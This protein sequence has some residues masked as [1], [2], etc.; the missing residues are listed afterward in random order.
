MLRL[1]HKKL[2][3]TVHDR[4]KVALK[5][6]SSFDMVFVALRLSKRHRKKN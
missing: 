5:G 3:Y 1:D 2:E 4:V 6:C